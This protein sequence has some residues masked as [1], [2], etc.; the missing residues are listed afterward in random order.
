MVTGFA[1]LFGIAALLWMGTCVQLRR[2][3]GRSEALARERDFFQT[4]LDTVPD[5]IY[6][7]D[8][9]SRF[10]RV[11]QA[12][13]TTLNVVSPSDAIGKSDFDFFATE[14]AKAFRAD[15]L[16]VLS[17]R[18]PLHDRIE[19]GTINGVERWM[20]TTKAPLFDKNDTAIGLVG[21]SRDITDRIKAEKNLSELIS[22]ARCILW[23]ARVKAVDGNFDWRI[24]FHSSEQLRKDLDLTQV[25]WTSH[26]HPEQLEKMN[27]MSHQAM[28]SGAD[29]YN[30]EFWVTTR[31]GDVRWM[32]EDVRIEKIADHEWDLV[33]VG[34]DITE[35]KRF[36]Q[37]LAAVND[38]LARLANE[39]VL[40]GLHNR[41]AILNIAET[42][43]LRW[44][45]YKSLFSVLILDVDNFKKIN[46][47][48][49]HHDGDAALKH[50][51]AHLKKSIRKIDSVGRYGGEEFVIILPETS[52]EGAKVLAQKVLSTIRSS[53]IILSGDSVKI[54]VSIGAAIAM[55]TDKNFAG[56][57]HRADC[58]LCQAKRSGKDQVLMALET[59]VAA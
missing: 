56:L 25:A 37:E 18:A 19:R 1:I 24:D 32:N 28:L 44:E 12:V 47:T 59:H 52:S 22:K 51:A 23:N 50:I 3:M 5:Q 27:A 20:S 6:F 7:K 53:T 54:T 29:G 43:W 55:P 33:G 39:D 26:I 14:D 16:K 34:L 36:E 10:V 35:R 17:S 30:Q 8:A 49:G 45:R 13:A 31:G 38:K 57:I 4:L 40:T 58:A 42:E 11:S 46:D 41:R 15:D 9:E 21:I 2:L 48:Y